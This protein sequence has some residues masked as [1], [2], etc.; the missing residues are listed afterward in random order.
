MKIATE[1]KKPVVEALTT[2]LQVVAEAKLIKAIAV[3][4]VAAAS[5]APVVEYWLDAFTGRRS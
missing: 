1:S 3:E 2:Q 5:E 4:Q